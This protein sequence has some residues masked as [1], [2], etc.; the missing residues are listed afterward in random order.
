MQMMSCPHCGASNSVKRELC[1]QCQKPLRTGPAKEQQA[2]A[3]VVV[4][5][6]ADCCYASSAPPLGRHMAHEQVWCSHRDEPVS[7]ARVASECYEPAFTW[8]RDQI[9]D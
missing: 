3:G 8:A 9:V 5:S 6:C 4:T 2:E 7:A 1:Y